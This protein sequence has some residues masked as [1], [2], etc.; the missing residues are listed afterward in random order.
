[1]KF[2]EYIKDRMFAVTA[3]SAAAFLA[4]TFMTIME[5]ALPVITAVLIIFFFGLLAAFV[6]DFVRK[7]QY[8]D[9]L[10]ELFCELDEKTY[11]CEM[12]E[13]PDFLDGRILYNIVKTNGK[14]LNDVI[15]GQQQE[16]LEYKDYVQTWAHEI[17]TPISVERLIIENNKNPLTQSM[18][19][20][21]IKIEN[22]VEQML[23][24]TKAGSLEEDYHIRPVPLKTLCM[25]AVRKNSK[26]MVS[27][28]VFPRFED[29]DAVV[30]T[31]IKWME[32]ILGQVITNAVKYHK[33]DGGSWLRFYTGRAVD[34]PDG[35]ICLNV[36]DN[37]IGILPED[38]SR[39]FKKGFTG[40]NGRLYKGSTGMGLYLCQCLCAKMGI[41]IELMSTYGEGTTVQFYMKCDNGKLLL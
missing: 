25:G 4:A 12:I 31:D 39:V 32:F 16:I 41:R 17:K 15:A 3:I 2:S 38:M 8:Y 36:E 28:K 33:K 23:Y 27:E 37:G 40:E 6:Y 5:V 24:Y 20:E 9:K 30:L 34:C 18:E 29:L 14:Y 13:E 35:Y 21:V 7:K 1:M 11:L 26:L 22:Y 10:S 19:E